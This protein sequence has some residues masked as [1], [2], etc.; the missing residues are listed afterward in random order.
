MS[1]LPPQPIFVAS[2]IEGCQELWVLVQVLFSL[3]KR[4]QK[5]LNSS[6]SS[7]L[8]YPVLHCSKLSLF[9]G[10]ATAVKCP[11]LSPV[12]SRIVSSHSQWP[13]GGHIQISY[14]SLECHM[15]SPA[16]YEPPDSS[17]TSSWGKLKMFLQV[18]I[19]LSFLYEVNDNCG[20]FIQVYR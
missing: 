16:D 1:F 12:Q 14:M 8:C 10:P 4:A 7:H 18:N 19:C 3:S 17:R 15:S 11:S 5:A 2:K 13:S 6:R 20:I 9:E